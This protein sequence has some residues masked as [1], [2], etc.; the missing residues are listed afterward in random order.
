MVILY[1]AAHLAAYC[2]HEAQPW[3]A[4]TYTKLRFLAGSR[5]LGEV[6]MSK[7]EDAV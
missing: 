6:A 1:S 2:E 3:E 5:S 7:H 4:L